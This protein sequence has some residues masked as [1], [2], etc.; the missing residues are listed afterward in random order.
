MG[1]LGTDF[2]L[3]MVQP[4]LL[5]KKMN[6]GWKICMYLM[7]NK[8]ACAHICVTLTLTIFGLFWGILKIK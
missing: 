4:S 5:F 3:A 7:K 8:H 6:L 1:F 2:S